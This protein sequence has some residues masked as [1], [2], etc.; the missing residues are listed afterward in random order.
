[1]TSFVRRFSLRPG[2]WL[3]A[4]AMLIVVP[5]LT[6]PDFAE[7]LTPCD[8]Q[9][10]GLNVVVSVESDLRSGGDVTDISQTLEPAVEVA[11]GQTIL[12]IASLTPQPDEC[13]G[14]FSIDWELAFI[15]F[16]LLDVKTSSEKPPGK[17]LEVKLGPRFPNASGDDYI[18]L[19]VRDGFGTAIRRVII[20]LKG[21]SS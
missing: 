7:P 20:P 16:S 19:V 5:F 10:S 6:L 14:T 1:M 4:C 2:A 21:K 18:H 8:A 17:Q 15:G 11:S 12:I 9:L 3:M 13:S